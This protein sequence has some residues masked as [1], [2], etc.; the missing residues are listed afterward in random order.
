[1]E[2]I[3]VVIM[4]VICTSILYLIEI[5]LTGDYYYRVISNKA[6]PPISVAKKT[7][8]NWSFLPGL[9]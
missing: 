5:S 2:V 7:G 4:V 8:C 6:I 9:G 1:M 3:V